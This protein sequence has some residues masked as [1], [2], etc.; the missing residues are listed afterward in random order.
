[1]VLSG[2][3]SHKKGNWCKKKLRENLIRD[4]SIPIQESEMPPKL[5]KKAR[6]TV[7]PVIHRSWLQ[8][9]TV[10]SWQLSATRWI[11][12]GIG[13]K[14]VGTHG[15]VERFRFATGPRCWSEAVI[16]QFGAEKRT[17]RQTETLT[18]SP[19]HWV[20]L[21]G[22]KWLQEK[23]HQTRPRM[24][25][26]RDGATLYKCTPTKTAVPCTPH[27]SVHTSRQ[28]LFSQDK[29]LVNWCYTKAL[30]GQYMFSFLSEKQWDLHKFAS[31]WCCWTCLLVFT[32]VV[33]SEVRE[34]ARVSVSSDT[35]LRLYLTAIFHSALYTLTAHRKILCS[36]CISDKTQ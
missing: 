1:M 15:R 4:V 7:T 28:E 8:V 18:L 34:A 32:T 10:A 27:S 29:L 21:V 19:I 12:E 36:V 26:Y 23:T 25:M 30:Q 33:C 2:R 9:I 31:H 5:L 22:R 11:L 20:E 24:G 35:M 16:L 14:G 3:F 17:L 6:S 13:K